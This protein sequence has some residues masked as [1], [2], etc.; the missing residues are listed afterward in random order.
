MVGNRSIESSRTSLEAL[1]IRHTRL[2][3]KKCN[4]GLNSETNTSL[5]HLQTPVLI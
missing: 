1:T 3:G 2:N 5:W 4:S